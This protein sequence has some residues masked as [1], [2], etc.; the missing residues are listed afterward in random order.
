VAKSPRFEPQWVCPRCGTDIPVA[1]LGSGANCPCGERY[2]TLGSVPVLV[3]DSARFISGQLEAATGHRDGQ[4]A[5]L[6]RLAAART[7]SEY[8][9]RAP[10]IDRWIE[11]LHGN[12]LLLDGFTAELERAVAAIGDAAPDGGRDAPTLDSQYGFNN[13]YLLW[14]DWTDS[15]D[16][17]RQRRTTRAA[18][19]RLVGEAGGRAVMLGAGTGRYV[20]DLAPRFEHMIAL[21]L[22]PLYAHLFAEVR[23][24]RIEFYISHAF[25]PASV[26]SIVERHLT[27]GPTGEAVAHIAYAIADARRMPL[28]DGSQDIVIAIYFMDVV[29]IRELAP[30]IARVLVPGG[31][32]VAYGPLRYHFDDPLDTLAPEELEGM[33]ERFGLRP[34][35]VTWSD[36]PFFSSR[37]QAGRLIDRTGAWVFERRDGRDGSKRVRSPPHATR[38]ERV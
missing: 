38:V 7:D 11:A 26:D 18:I 15:A 35:G 2:V 23:R 36:A 1:D 27:A 28:R 21:D 30:E 14:A 5:V 34:V 32:F 33:F 12:L 19:D 29:P 8:A 31:R 6:A 13:L 20:V 4:R 37:A 16:A 25:S 10:A 3:R 22:C 9:W 17:R 24:R